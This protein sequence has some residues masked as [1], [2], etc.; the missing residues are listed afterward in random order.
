MTVDILF[1]LKAYFVTLEKC[2]V[3]LKGFFF[4]FFLNNYHHFFLPFKR[5]VKSHLPSAGI[6]RSSP[7]SPR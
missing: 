1:A 3:T 2:P 4:F 5:G 7:Y 6:I